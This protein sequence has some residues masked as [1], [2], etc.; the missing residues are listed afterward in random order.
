MREYGYL[1][2]SDFAI[3]AK[4]N[5]SYTCNKTLQNG[6]AL[7][8]LSTGVTP[9][10]FVSFEKNEYSTN[11]PQEF[12]SVSSELGLLTESV[13]DDA[14]V[15]SPA[16]V[17]TAQF[18][19]YYSM[20]GITIHSR[21]IIKNITITAYRDDDVIKTSQF[22]ANDYEFFYN[23]DVSLV[24][25][26]TFA[27]SEIEE[28][29]H[30]FCIYNIE[31][32][33]I[34]FFDDENISSIEIANRC[35]VDGE[36]I[37]YDTLSLVINKD[38]SVDYL[39]QAKQPLD[40]IKDNVVK[41]RFF[42]YE[43]GEQDGNTIRVTAYD[44]V[45][46]LENDFYGGIY[47]N[48]SF[49]SLV[50]DIMDGTGVSYESVGTSNILL[51]GYIPI[52]SRRKA[53]QLVLQGSNIRLLKKEKLVLEALQ[54]TTEGVYTETNIAD[55]PQITKK[56]NVKSVIVKNHNYTKGT[57]EV[58]LYHW[59]V[60]TVKDVTITFPYPVHS[61][62]AYEVTGV[63]EYGND[64]I[65]N[66]QSANVTFVSQGANFC[67]IRNTSSN[68]IVIKGKKYI[69]SVVEYYKTSQYISPTEKY[70][71]ITYGEITIVSSPQS[72]CDYL[73]GV[74]T[75]HTEVAFV[76]IDEPKIGGRYE[77]LGE[78]YNLKTVKHN[79]TGVYEVE[80]V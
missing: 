23:F 5:A 47:S 62:S 75:N 33:K 58:E 77:I 74:A 39:F 64:I 76:T 19:D 45:S 3:G 12:V 50:S 30:F 11:A 18:T 34:R 72:V 32:G 71:D 28:A 1:R 9:W 27:V 60:S 53:L 29:G 24:N 55:A 57:E 6:S 17:L 44:A 13:S 40:Y 25:K 37:E 68:K 52:C 46:N 79:M 36:T 16:V 65:S 59:Y 10:H 20:T 67:S 31:Y 14:G 69:D 21:N 41:N 8:Q 80:A 43:G 73:Y 54:G 63:D 66:T 51:T 7:S 42:V 15:F 2:Y 4:E 22:S 70:N 61:L 48:Y 35:S 38:E 56:Q 78:N 49:D 26:I